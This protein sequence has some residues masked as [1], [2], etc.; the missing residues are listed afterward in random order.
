MAELASM[1]M[2]ELRKWHNEVKRARS[3]F[4][5]DSGPVDEY[6]L[7]KKSRTEVTS[8][9]LARRLGLAVGSSG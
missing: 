3:E 1:T 2:E 9:E 6:V 4:E 8:S 7:E 5:Q